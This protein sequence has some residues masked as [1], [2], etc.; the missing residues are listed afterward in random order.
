MLPMD[1]FV[2]LLYHGVT[3]RTHRGIQNC[4]RKQLPSAQFER[5]MEHLAQGYR[6]LPLRELVRLSVARAVPTRAVAVTFD[7]GFENNCSVAF[8]ILERFQIPATFFLS[9][10]HIGTDKAFWVDKVEYLLN[11]TAEPE[12]FLPPL[13]RS[14]RLRTLADREG[15]LTEIKAALKKVPGLIEP[16]VSEMECRLQVAPR[17]DYPD[18]RTLSWD[19]VRQMRRSGLYEFG[20]HSVDHA[21]LTHLNLAEK[22]A[23]IRG[24][25]ETL[26][27]ELQEPVDLFSYP[28]GQGAHFDEET[29]GLLRSAGFS[30]S[31]TALFGFNTEETSPFHLRRNMV[32]FA[33]P[34]E[35]CLEP[36]HAACR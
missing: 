14:F 24:S 10:G 31:C 19:Q 15:A 29:I 26:E 22:E 32:E 25:Q 16:T 13:E 27:R 17:Y 36:L 23:Q 18:Y 20:A 9:T 11:E 7:D 3:E 33:A 30:V 2:I 8:P 4:S 12:L 21:I 5:Q 6:V 34:F 28:E 1:R 35:E